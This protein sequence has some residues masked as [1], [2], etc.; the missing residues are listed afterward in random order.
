M[1]GWVHTRFSHA[2][3]VLLFF[4]WYICKKE[5]IKIAQ[6]FPHCIT[7]VYYCDIRSRTRYAIVGIIAKSRE[8]L[9]FCVSLWILRCLY[10]S[11]PTRLGI[12]YRP[13]YDCPSQS[14][15]LCVRLSQAGMS[16]LETAEQIRLVLSLM[17]PLI[18]ISYAALLRK[19]WYLQNVVLL[20]GTSPKLWLINILP[21]SADR[22]VVNS[23]PRLVASLSHL[24][25]ISVYSTMCE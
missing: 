7:N 19:F 23:L 16:K 2:F 21:R 1:P 9:I 18:G 10:P 11:Y 15:C 13:V 17:I 12:S 14:V 3:F 24:R 5:L 20:P 8:S 25:S 4:V 6:I 22:R